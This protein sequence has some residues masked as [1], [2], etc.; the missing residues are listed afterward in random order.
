MGLFIFIFG[1]KPE[2]FGLD[3]SIAVGF[4]QMGVFSFGLILICFGGTL[5]LDSLWKNGYR[6]IVAD[7]GLRLSWT[8][9]IVSLI[10]GLA[11]MIGVG[12]RPFPEYQIF[13][14]HWQARGIMIG[15]IIMMIGFLMV[16]PYKQ[17]ETQ[18]EKI[19]TDS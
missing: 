4:V 6:S 17:G 7:L 15:Q 10:S 19:N 11:D 16:I 9:L 2:W 1:A 12:T 5:S 14:G 18:S 8:G 13:F 3:R